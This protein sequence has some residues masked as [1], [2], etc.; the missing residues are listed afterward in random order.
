MC[1]LRSFRRGT[2]AQIKVELKNVAITHYLILETAANNNK[3]KAFLMEKK[4]LTAHIIIRGL[5]KNVCYKIR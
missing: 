4:L 2:A 3:T 5:R 1:T